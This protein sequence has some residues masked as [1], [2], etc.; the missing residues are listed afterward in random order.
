MKYIFGFKQIGFW[1]IPVV[2]FAWLGATSLGA[3]EPIG[4]PYEPDSATVLLLHFDG[5]LTN[6][7]DL[8]ADARSH[9]NVAFIGQSPIDGGQSIYLD[10]DSPADSS[11]IAVADTPALDLTGS[12]TI[13]AWVN[14]FT[15]GETSEDHRWQPRLLIKPGDDPVYYNNFTVYMAGNTRALRTAYY[16]PSGDQW[17]QMESQAG[18]LNAGNWYHITFIRDT[19]EHITAQLV[20]DKDMNQLFFGSLDYDPI[21]GSPPLPSSQPV[22]IGT[23][24]GLSSPWFDGFVEEFRISNVVRNFALPPIISG[25]TQLGNQSVENSYVIEAEIFKIG[26]GD[27]AQATLHYNT[28]SGWQELAMNNTSGRQYSAQIPSQL[29]G[30]RVQYYI[31]AEDEFGARATIPQTAELDSVFYEFAIWQPATQTLALNF[32]EGSGLPQDTTLYGNHSEFIG[33]PTYSTDAAVGDYSLQFEG[34]SSYLEIDSPFLT[35]E[36]FTV[37]FWF[38][39]DSTPVDGTRMLIKEGSQSWFQINYQI[40]FGAGGQLV[41]ASYIPSTGNYIGTN[42]ADTS[43]TIEAHKWYRLIFEVGDGYASYELRDSTN[44][45]ISDNS[46]TLEGIPAQATGPFRLAHANGSS[47]N[48]FQGKIDNVQI[49]N[50]PR[51][52]IA[53][54][55]EPD[56]R[57]ELPNEIRL[58]SNY[59]NPF[60]PVTTIEFRVPYRQKVALGVYDILGRKVATLISDEVE[61]GPHSVQWTGKNKWGQPVAS[62]VYFYRLKTPGDLRIR[63]MVLLR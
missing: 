29:R 4:G 40:R 34:D 6:E 21:T 37:D 53:T 33:N 47:Q 63:K 55:A 30:T 26:T 62:G 22:Y 14:I 60:N 46:I 41:P 28:G 18:L 56:N 13:E 61:S 57:P 8:T 39:A 54:N 43:A 36:E 3:Q 38:K 32:E 58:A 12:W 9:G 2:L 20:H 16:T 1:S 15:Y 49:Y 10:N 48:F 42:L 31:S 5:N 23:N 51:D 45:M 7:T 59:P 52:S 24:L 25:V 17:I 50:F 27:V 19:S 11:Y 44:T 35:S